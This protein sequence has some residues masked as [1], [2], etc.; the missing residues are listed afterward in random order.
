M[1]PWG[2]NQKSVI[3]ANYLFI[4]KGCTPGTKKCELIL[5]KIELES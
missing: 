1:V 3:L 5:E 4:F 2:T